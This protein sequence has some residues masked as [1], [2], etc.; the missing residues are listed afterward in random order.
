MLHTPRPQ[1]RDLSMIQSVVFRN[2]TYDN[3]G[4]RLTQNKNGVI[5]NYTYSALSGDTHLPA[6]DAKY[7]T[8]KASFF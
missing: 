8:C 7:L 4:N 6:K 5:T 2:W 3:V 1:R